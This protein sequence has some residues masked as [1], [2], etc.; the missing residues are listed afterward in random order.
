MGG[1]NERQSKCSSRE[2]T[3]G[4]ACFMQ[5]CS[6]QAPS[7]SGVCP[8]SKTREVVANRKALIEYPQHLISLSNSQEKP[9][10]NVAETGFE[11]AIVGELRIDVGHPDIDCLRPLC[12]G[13]HD[14][15]QGG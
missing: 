14:T 8:P 3:V 12:S 13:P 7:H 11:H 6:F 15:W 5:R 4:T 9:V 10:T 2:Q 1:T